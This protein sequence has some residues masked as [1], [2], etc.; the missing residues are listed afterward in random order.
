[1]CTDALSC[2]QGEDLCA[3]VHICGRTIVT[4]PET[5]MLRQKLAH[6]ALGL[7]LAAAPA[8]RTTPAPATAAAR[9][10]AVYPGAE[11]ERVPSPEAV[12]WSS[13]GLDSVRAEL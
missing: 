7:L 13:A 10:A 8:C 6:L 12:G 3:S 2:E 11:W 9:V 5:S 4:P 1:M